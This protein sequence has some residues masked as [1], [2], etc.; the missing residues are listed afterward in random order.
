MNYYS[1]F[2]HMLIKI[3]DLK[4]APF[5]VIFFWHLESSKMLVI[6]H[7][8][9]IL[10]RYYAHNI[11]CQILFSGCM[12]NVQTEPTRKP[13][14]SQLIIS[15]KYISKRQM[16]CKHI[17][18]NIT[19]TLKRDSQCF[20]SNRWHISFFG[21]S[22]SSFDGFLGYFSILSQTTEVSRFWNGRTES[23]EKYLGIS[24]PLTFL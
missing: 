17:Q 18:I 16:L 24:T 21:I 12:I 23:L 11:Y 3:V 10:W 7:P 6:W 1:K 4:I 22:Q 19:L 2:L 9:C 5:H 20:L 14:G 8:S 15:I 13:I